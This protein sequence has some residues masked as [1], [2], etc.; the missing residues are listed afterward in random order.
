[1]EKKQILGLS[2]AELS[3]YLTSRELSAVEVTDVF[4]R[5]LREKEEE[6]GAFLTVCGEQ[7]ADAAAALDKRRADGE[8]L[9]P[10]AGVPMALKDN[11]CTKGILTTCASQMLRGFVPP[12]DATVWEKL[13]EQGTVLL[14]KLNMDEFAMGSSNENSS[15]HPTR[16]P[17]DPSRVPGGSSGGSA[18][19]VAAREVPFALGSDTGGSIRQP[20][21]FCGVVGMKPTYGRVSRYG[22]VAFASSLD[23]IGPLTSDVRDN[24]IVLGA[25]AGKDPRDATCVSLPVPDYTAELEKGVEGLVIGVPKQFFGE[26]LAPAVKDAVERAAKTLEELGA[27]LKELSLSAVDY[28]LPAYYV[29]SSAEASS[30]LSRFDGVRYGYRAENYDDIT[31]LYSASRSEGFG[32]EVKRRIMIGTFALSA[33]YYDAYYKKAL[34]VRTLIRRELEQAL[35]TCD[36][37]L[38]PVSPTTAYRLGEKIADPLQMYLGDVYTVPANIAGLPAL[39]LPCGEDG[40]GLPI[41][42]QLLGRAF[43]ES[44]LYRVGY[45]F[46]QTG[47]ERK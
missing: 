10:L 26:G 17:R 47:K 35:E 22:L 36:V 41:G 18:A 8:T 7:A 13:R 4:L 45:A 11:L 12:Y 3:K 37:I 38:S 29:L 30:N 16:N 39:S 14:G 40:D 33:G 25:I 28:A 23:Q 42:M 46:E 20:A 19:A 31:D 24:A 44:T 34:Q 5:H 21:S 32:S 1:M 9:P 15:F 6:I 43:D 27:K 2:V